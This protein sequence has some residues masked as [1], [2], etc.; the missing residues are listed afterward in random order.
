M[1]YTYI[2]VDN[3]MHEYGCKEKLVKH[4]YSGVTVMAGSFNALQFRLTHKFTA[5]FVHSCSMFELCSF[6]GE[7]FPLLSMVMQYSTETLPGI[8]YT[9]WQ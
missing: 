3:L 7:Y 9:S 8:L 2:I 1:P 4:S 5:L 6:S